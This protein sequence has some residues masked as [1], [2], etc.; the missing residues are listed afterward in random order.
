[1]I[2][3][4]VVI[5]TPLFL[6]LIGITEIYGQV[7]LQVDSLEFKA[8]S[9][10]LN[11]EYDKAIDCYTKSLEIKVNTFGYENLGV[12]KTYN[13]LGNVYEETGEY[14]QS[15][16]FYNKSL[17][18]K[19]G[20]FGEMHPGVATTYNNLGIIYRKTAQY[21]LAIQYYEKSGRHSAPFFYESNSFVNRITPRFWQHFYYHSRSRP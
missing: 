4:I 7:N 13:N 5:L 18:I 2:N 21:G 6:G 14:E 19:K 3:R 15:M 8:R 11:N 1:M 12:A 20:L 9:Y 16:V 17:E 10:T